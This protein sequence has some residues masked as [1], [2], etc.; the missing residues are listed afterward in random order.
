MSRFLVLTS[1]TQ[2]S[3]ATSRTAWEMA[4]APHFGSRSRVAAAG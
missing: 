2:Y 1:S 3:S 4:T